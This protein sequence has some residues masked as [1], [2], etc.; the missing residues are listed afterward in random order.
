MRGKL[1][2]VAGAA[3]GYVLG[4]RAGHKRYDQIAKA[5]GNLWN[6]GSVQRKVQQVE[7]FAKDKSPAVGGFVAGKVK[8]A[9]NKSSSSRKSG[10]SA[11]DSS[12]TDSSE[13]GSSDTAS[14]SST[15]PNSTPSN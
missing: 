13:T 12:G 10:G 4:S 3:V 7:E 15:S 6:S 11:S 1:M 14:D 8:K 9:V 2:L 5:A